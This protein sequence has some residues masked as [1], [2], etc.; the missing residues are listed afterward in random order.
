MP[1]SSYNI[2]LIK[3]M[4][5][6]D[7]NYIRLLKL[8]PEL[9]VYRDGSFADFDS[10]NS[11]EYSAQKADAIPDD[12][13]ETRLQGLTTRF[14]I[15]DLEEH[16]GKVSVEITIVEAFKYTCTLEIVQ[17]PE[18]RQWMTNPS[19]Q[20]R[21]YHDASTAEVVSYQGHRNL[22]PRYSQPNP[23]MYHPDEK[24]QVNQFLGEWLTHCLNVGRSAKVPDLL[25]SS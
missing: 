2:D 10:D 8:V 4:A 20:V 25:F 12:E 19:M 5:E 6:C 13:P 7:A 18:F 17:R 15:A 11:A 24:M 14:S 22:K 16:Q 23:D 21:V 9:S 1:K 3:Q